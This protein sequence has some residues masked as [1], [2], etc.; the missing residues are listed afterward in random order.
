MAMKVRAILL[1]VIDDYIEV[2]HEQ[3][4]T[5]KQ[6]PSIST[7]GPKTTPKTRLARKLGSWPKTGLHRR[8]QNQAGAWASPINEPALPCRPLCG[9]IL[10]GAPTPRGSAN[11]TVGAPLPATPPLSRR[12]LPPETSRRFLSRRCFPPRSRLPAGRQL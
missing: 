5:W 12:F 7:G 10:S 1:S 4:R 3:P 6:V 2:T 11:P 8:P 9:R